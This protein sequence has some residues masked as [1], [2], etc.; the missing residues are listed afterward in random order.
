MATLVLSAAGMALGGSLGGSVL[1]LSAAA[2]GRAAG[3]MLGRAID[4]R[5]LGAG[6]APVETGRVDRFRLT[7]ASEGTSVTRIHGAVRLGGQVI[8]AT[9]FQESSTTTGGGK[10]APQPEVTQFSYSVSLAVALCEGEISGVGRIWA[11]GVE[12]P[13]GDLQISVYRGTEDQLPDPR[14]E[15]VEGAGRVPAYRG[16]AYVVIEDLPLGRFGNR[17]P[18]FSF[19]VFRPAPQRSDDSA[20]DIARLLRGVA[21]IPGTGEY[22]LATTPVYLS[23]GFAE[24]KAANIS[25]PQGKADLLVSLDSLE[26]ELPRLRSVSLVACWFGGDLR[27]GHCRIEPKVEQAQADGEGMPWSVSGL[28][29]DTARLVPRQDDQ[30]VYGGTPTDASVI[31]AIREIRQRGKQVVFYPFLLM[32]QMAGNALP[33]PHGS[34]GQPPLPWRG[35]ITLS[36]APGRPGSPDGTAA[37]DAEV[38]AFFGQAESSHFVRT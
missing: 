4:E 20:E 8:W 34:A 19:E 31:Q 37:A 33:D 2:A 26:T 12:I 11:D 28:S 16:I 36:V 38:A 24:R 25:T 21:L 22:A 15:A 30:P 35:R 5:I 17:V 10:G 18:Q 9:R 23:T 13:T 14:M 27:A 3:A 1:G 29:R 7:G 32:D 6:S